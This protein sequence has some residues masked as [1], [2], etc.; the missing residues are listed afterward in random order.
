MDVEQLK[1]DVRQGRIS[2]DRL[3][4]L[5]ISALRALDDAKRRIQELE[6]KLSSGF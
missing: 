3:A 6:E 4:D 2:A 5:L 1:E